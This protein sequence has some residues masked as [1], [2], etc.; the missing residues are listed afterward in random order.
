M[1]RLSTAEFERALAIP[2]AVDGCN[3]IAVPV[4]KDGRFYLH[5]GNVYINVPE[6]FVIPKCDKCG[7]DMF[8][9]E[10]HRALLQVLEVEYQVHAEMIRKIIAK[11]AAVQ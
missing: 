5:R 2:C 10:L 11:D 9:E 1:H 6:S 8:T 4:K 3:G 7:M